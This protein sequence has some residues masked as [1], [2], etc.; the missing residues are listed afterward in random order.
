VDFPS[1]TSSNF[2]I[3]FWF[4]HSCYMLRLLHSPWLNHSDNIW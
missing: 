2:S 4:N 1:D 3:C